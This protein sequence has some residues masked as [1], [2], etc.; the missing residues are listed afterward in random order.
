MR[1]SA[2]SPDHKQRLLELDV[3]RGVAILLVVLFHTVVPPEKSGALRPFALA[4]HNFG[5]TGVDL[6]FVLSGFLVGGLLLNEIQTRG[7]L[8]VKR[9][10]VRRGFKIWPSFYVYL[11]FLTGY[12]AF[13]HDKG[14][15]QAFLEM[16]PNYLHLQNFL[17][18]PRGHTWSLAVEEHFYLALPL[19]LAVA[20]R[21][22]SLAQTLT[23]TG[24]L[25]VFGCGALRWAFEGRP[26][27]EGA[28]FLRLDGLFLG[29][30]IAYGRTFHPESFA[31]FASN[32]LPIGVV[33]VVALS[34]MVL[35]PP[36]SYLVSH[37][38]KSLLAIGYAGLLVAVLGRGSECKRKPNPLARLVAWVGVYSY[39]VYLWHVDLG[40]YPVKALSKTGLF[41][42]SH[43]LRWTALTLAYIACSVAAGVVMGKLVER[44]AL[45]LR[46]RLF[47]S[48]APAVRI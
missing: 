11:G 37:F 20:M 41:A 18:S 16:V 12:L 38:G 14:L 29:V 28:T 7:S 5:W 26:L 43:E 48:R 9:F 6:F 25:F 33:S 47:P 30:L 3:L 45:A 31:R 13:G 17:G 27:P 19:L 21:R 23:V 10:I 36:E 34:P 44:P 24:G 39:P 2:K 42:W 40:L 35:L 32:W 15:S 1:S 46:D 22:G 8:D 4:F